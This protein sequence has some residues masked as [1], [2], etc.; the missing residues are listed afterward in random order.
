MGNC[1]SGDHIAG[2]NIHRD[3][4]CDI[5]NHNRSTALERS[6]ID[7]WGLKHVLLDPNIALCFGYNSKQPARV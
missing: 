4:T 6:V 5:G 7:Y 2:D 3:I 1:Y